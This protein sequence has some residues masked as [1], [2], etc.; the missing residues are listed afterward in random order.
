MIPRTLVPTDV[1]PLTKE[2]SKKPPRRL[3]TYMDDRTVVPSELSDAP[4]L[5]GKT[6][7]PEHLPLGVLV[8][9]TLVA[10][11]MPAKPFEDFGPITEHIPIAILDSRVVVPAFVEPP[12]QRE[13]DKFDQPPQMT[14]ALRELVEPD[15]F[16]TGEANLLVESEDKRSAK[17]DFLTRAF[18]IGFH[19]AFII[20]LISLPKLFPPHVPTR[21]EIE[22]ASKEL[23]VVY[24]PSDVNAVSRTPT[25]PAPKISSK[26]LN[27]V[28]PPR[29][30]SHMAEL[31]PP[32]NPEKP[33]SDLPAAP[34]PRPN[35]TPP[36]GTIASNAPVVPSAVLPVQPSVQPKPGLN[37]GLPN[38][39]P[40]KMMDNQI[41]DAINHSGGSGVY[42][43]G[44]IPS[45]AGR[46][47]GQGPIGGAGMSILTDTEGVSF[48]SYMTQLHAIVMKNWIAVM[49]ESYYM[50]ERG[51]VVITFHI[52][53]DGTIYVTEPILERTS[54]K[55]ALDRAVMAAIHT[56]VPLPPL[57]SQF[58]GPFI[59]LR[60]A[61]YY[62]IKP[63][64]EQ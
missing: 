19:V 17:E 18:S 47:G 39:S 29:P 36:P 34:T 11:G 40:G 21:D 7:I 1:R 54:G 61:F 57:P 60:A 3:T 20:F 14:A 9:R 62:N 30:E 63:G 12:E 4:P 38:A 31:P 53:R 46:G 41:Q 24:L 56:S 22:L 55:E 33:I 25:P 50:G 37:L 15:V 42:T 28:A 23:G 26:T 64:S 45:G 49:P 10:R 58:K 43:G 52:N 2:D 16:N 59:E 27:R 6:N 5:D 35:A 8:D 32:G 48:D 44:G 51:I 13:I